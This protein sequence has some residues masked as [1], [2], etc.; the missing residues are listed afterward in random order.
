MK[1]SEGRHLESLALSEELDTPDK[2]STALAGDLPAHLHLLC[3]H[4]HT[5]YY[6]LS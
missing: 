3:M 1:Q 4:P 5:S 2:R 6:L